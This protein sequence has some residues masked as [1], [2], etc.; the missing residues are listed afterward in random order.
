MGQDIG[1]A[2]A[3]LNSIDDVLVNTS[4]SDKH[5]REASRISLRALSNLDAKL[6]GHMR[7]ELPARGRAQRRRARRYDLFDEL[8]GDHVLVTCQLGNASIVIEAEKSFTGEIGAPAG[9]QAPPGR[10]YLFD[11]KTGERLR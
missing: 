6:R 8:M 7:A 2:C 1:H 10:C 3:P 4:I 11:N 9:V 5:R